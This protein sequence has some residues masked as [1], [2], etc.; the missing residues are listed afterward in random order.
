MPHC[1]RLRIS[2]TIHQRTRRADRWRYPDPAEPTRS[3]CPVVPVLTGWATR[4]TTPPWNKPS[5]ENR[6][7]ARIGTGRSRSFEV[8]TSDP[9]RGCKPHGVPGTGSEE[10]GAQP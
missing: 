8:Q 5:A 1:P 10:L 4:R 2:L 6:F 3:H 9:E 7:A